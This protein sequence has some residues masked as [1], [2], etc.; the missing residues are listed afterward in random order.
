MEGG[1]GLWAARLPLPADTSAVL[2]Y[3]VVAQWQGGAGVTAPLEGAVS[4]VVVD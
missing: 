2:E 1:R 3:I 4:V